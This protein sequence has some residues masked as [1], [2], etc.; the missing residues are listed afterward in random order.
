MLGDYPMNETV[1]RILKLIQEHGISAHKLEVES[2]IA[3]SSIQAWKNGKSKP[4]AP[5]VL[6][7]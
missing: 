5:Y 4:S 1:A 2:K 6:T 3:I 7:A